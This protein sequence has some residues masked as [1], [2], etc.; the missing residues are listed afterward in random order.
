MFRLSHL[1]SFH[2]TRSC[3]G[4]H[5]FFVESCLSCGI[6]KRLYATMIAISAAIEDDVIKAFGQSPFS[7]RA[8]DSLRRFHVSPG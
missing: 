5:L 4:A 3:A 2:R 1:L 8:S 6:R 7:D